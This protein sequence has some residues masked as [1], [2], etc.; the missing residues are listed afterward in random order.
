MTH[1]LCRTFQRLGHETWDRIAAA[2]LTG[3][4]WSEE[5][6]TEHL[7]L[8]LKSHH[9]T[10]IL[11][12]A[13]SKAQEA[14]NGADWEWWFISSKA[15]HGMRVQAKRIKLPTEIFPYLNHKPKGQM[16]DQMTTFIQRARLD[17]LTPVYCF[18]VASR[19]LSR[20]HQYSWPAEITPP[21]MQ[22]SGCLIGHA[23][24]IR[25]TQSNS[26]RFLG[27]VL[28]PWHLLVCPQ[29]DKQDRD[30]ARTA[31]AAMQG[32]VERLLTVGVSTDAP[33]D[34]SDKDGPFLAEV[35]ERPP[36]Y[37]SRFMSSPEPDT[38]SLDRTLGEAQA[39]ERGIEGIV[40]FR[41][42]TE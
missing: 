42:L 4:P 15:A 8:E 25:R 24:E 27:P 41:Q 18:Y 2:D 16:Q 37:I 5:S 14:S 23:Q 31:A 3:T 32:A 13:F 39:S 38:P 17:N 35:L 40:V 33:Y 20:Q 26:L 29:T 12:T 6:N 19:R 11:L 34:Q 22:P 36:S 10:E 21:R 28:M 1:S 9:P 7:L 30:I